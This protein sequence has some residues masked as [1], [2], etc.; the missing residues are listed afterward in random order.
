MKKILRLVTTSVLTLTLVACGEA[1]S[2]VA[3]STPATSGSVS[4]P[5]SSFANVTGITISAASNTL[6][7]VVGATQT[8]SVVAAI[9]ANT[10]PNLALEWYV[11]GVKSQ[12]TG[13]VFEFVPTTVGAVK[14]QAKS[15]NVSSNELTVNLALPAFAVTSAA[16]VDAKQIK[17]VAPAGAAITLTGATLADTSKYDIKL[18]AYIIDLTAAV[19]QGDK[20]TVRL[21]RDG[22]TPITREVTFDTRVLE[23]DEFL[24]N[25]VE[26]TAK[27]DGV[28]EIV[29]PFDAGAIYAKTYTLVLAEE[30]LLP[31]APATI[32]LILENTV[33]VG[34]TAIPT[35]N[36]LV[37]SLAAI[38]FIVNSETVVG[39][40]TH[41]I[42]LGV[43]TLEVKV[44]VVAPV[45]EIII[46]ADAQSFTG[47]FIED[48]TLFD[49]VDGTKLTFDVAY[50]DRP[51]VLNAANEY[52]VTKPFSS[53]TPIAHNDV[54]GD[55][56]SADTSVSFGGVTY[57][58]TEAGANDISVFNKF[59]MNLLLQN[60]PKPDFGKNQFGVEISGP[61][62]ILGGT[63]GTLFNGIEVESTANDD[64][65]ALQIKSFQD[66]S[67][68]V[69]GAS[70]DTSHKIPFLQYID[71]GTPVGLYTVKVTAG[72]AG[73][74][75]TKEFKIRVVEPTPTLEFFI[76]RYQSQ[77]DNAPIMEVASD[78][79]TTRLHEVVK[80]GNTYTIEKPLTT[81]SIDFEWFTLL[82]NWQSQVVR[83]PVLLS[84]D[85]LKGMLDKEFFVDGNGV[86]DSSVMTRLV[87]NVG[88]QVSYTNAAG[89]SVTN[90][91]NAVDRLVGIGTEDN[92]IAIN[93]ERIAGLALTNGLT[94][95]SLKVA[96]KYTVHLSA[97]V[98][99]F[100]SNREDSVLTSSSAIEIPADKVLTID[101]AL[102]VAGDVA[103][104]AF[105]VYI[106]KLYSSDNT[107]IDVEPFVVLANKAPNTIELGGDTDEFAGDGTTPQ[108]YRYVNFEMASN[109]PTN[110]FPAIP[111]VKAAIRLAANT[112]GIVL[113]EQTSID[114]SD[115]QE[116]VNDLVGKADFALDITD[117][118]KYVDGN[119]EDDFGL[120]RKKLVI[121][122]TT[123]AGTYNLVFK[124]DTLELP[125]TIIIK[126][127]TPKIF[128]MSGTDSATTP[129]KLSFPTTTAGTEP[130][131][132]DTSST[133]KEF[134]KYYDAADVDFDAFGTKQP[135]SASD[136]FA[137]LVDGVYTI[138]M[139][140]NY[141]A[142]E[143]SGLYARI[144]VA[145]LALGVYDFKVVKT[146]PDGRV[147]KIE[148]K[149]EVTGLD[150][151]QVALFA[152]TDTVGVNNAVI[153][154]NFLINEDA[155]IKGQY[156]FEFTIGTVSKT[157]IVNVVDAPSLTV[158]TVK[159]GTT[160]L[161]LFDGRYS[162]KPA[163]YAG[164]LVMTF[165]P[166]MLDLE[167]FISISTTSNLASGLTN[168]TTDK[169]S[170]KLLD[171]SLALGTLASGARN[172]NDRIT[173]TI[174]FWDKVD[175]SL[176]SNG[177]I[178]VQTG[179]TQ[180]VTISFV[181]SN[182]PI[183]SATAVSGGAF[184]TELHL[185]V[186]SDTAGKV[187]YM[188]VANNAAAPTLLNLIEQGAS[189]TST[190]TVT[191]AK[192]GVLTLS[193][194]GSIFTHTVERLTA[195][196]ANTDYDLYYAVVGDNNVSSV[197]KV[198]A[199]TAVTTNAPALI[200]P[201]VGST[202]ILTAANATAFVIINADKYEAVLT[203]LASVVNTTTTDTALRD[204][205]RTATGVAGLV[206]NT[207]FTS[208]TTD[209]GA[210]ELNG[211]YVVVVKIDTNAITELGITAAVSGVTS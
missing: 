159:L 35:S 155:Y 30:D 194:S 136:L 144:A 133:S 148:D 45:K 173:Y 184:N 94:G 20:V 158:G 123:V 4:S 10:N 157:Y 52:V 139:K 111:A 178:Y 137:E 43:K 166:N 100:T 29:K 39:L 67:S 125:V 22:S 26:L 72:P 110:L 164:N 145:D 23:L 21:A 211:K 120:S 138:E 44:R 71:R 199:K 36:Q 126:N 54:N 115:L 75:I 12:Q 82:S 112:D 107:V 7:Q 74:E 210:T 3:S 161:S 167:Q 149:A 97:T 142:E 81:A 42:T 207:T 185:K 34:A 131:F 55:G 179:E 96:S 80:V 28:F 46:E 51:L 6:N 122:N 108:G 95:A 9:N 27:A 73:S 8:V 116:R 201:T 91:V 1:S 103:N 197:I 78:G 64:R 193:A 176:L 208:G 191:P 76:D 83:D 118:L 175:Y 58:E 93:A 79:L 38:P 135:P 77:V 92:L 119:D 146:Y 188:L 140:S 153:R 204:L 69:A 150:G 171:G 162:L 104:N 147:E 113:V 63:I 106:I 50:N 48:A 18:G 11:N 15:G 47:T 152:D 206:F 84:N 192:K 41:K 187:Y 87:D 172:K 68:A 154:D 66:F 89:S 117:V 170:L 160:T 180:T 17:V 177:T 202:G 198:D 14:V 2:S 40:Y 132:F 200:A 143:R 130:Y 53:K 33:P 85:S 86:K 156:K 65:N 102:D 62:A 101:S 196:T 90:E 98:T 16:F 60:F 37:N 203:V 128:V 186:N 189:Y 13:R 151:N 181:E 56:D 163:T 99:G 174:T 61:S 182:L 190:A 169:Q 127:P 31:V 70:V 57:N 195:L 5:V 114:D 165:T 209:I 124:V 205:L 141:D 25:N 183:A 134:L 88:V 24:V 32:S 109:G 49:Q 129:I 168:P 121:N 19:K 59:E 105:I